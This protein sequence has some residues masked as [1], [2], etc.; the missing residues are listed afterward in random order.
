M[1]NDETLEQTAPNQG[2][3][4]H[5][6]KNIDFGNVENLR[7]LALLTVTSMAE[8]LDTTRP[9]Y[10]NWLKGRKPKKKTAEHIRKVIRGLATLAAGGQWPDADAYNANQTT[11]VAM[12]KEKLATCW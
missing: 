1:N 11:R 5:T 6:L 8:L 3:F 4:R 7:K 9:S 2:Q 12:L 10:Y